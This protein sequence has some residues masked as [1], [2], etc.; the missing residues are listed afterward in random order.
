MASGQKDFL[1]S[2]IRD[3][4][5]M[6]FGQQLKLTMLLAVPAIL[7]QFSSVLMM[8]IDTAMVGHLGANPSASIGLV[9]TSTWI[10][11]GF[12]MA[13]AS[14]FSVQVAHMCGAKNF[15]GARRVL[16]QGLSSIF[17]FS[18]V[19]ALAGVAISPYLPAWLGGS[20]AI[21]ADASAYFRIYAAF[22]PIGA[23]GYGANAMLQGSGNMKVPSILYVSMCALD[24]V[25]NYLFIY[26]MEMG[27]AGAA[28][29]TGLA[30]AITT[31]V[32]LWFVLL[33]S[34]ELKI[35]GERGSFVPTKTV[36][37]NA[38][39]ITGPMWLQNLLM[40]GAHV[41][42]T[43]IVAPL[44]PIAIAANAFAIT[45]ESFCYMPGYGLEEAATT[46]VG[47]SLGASRKHIA[48]R[49]ARITIWMAAAIM[50]FLAV[51]MFF[52]ARDLM[53]LLSSDPDVIALGAKVLRIEAFAETFYAVSIVAY[54]ACVGAGDTLIPTALNFASMWVVR[55]GLAFYLTPR[56]GLVGYWIAMCIELNVRGLLFL[57]H[58]RGDRW[59][60]KRFTPV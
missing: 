49:F 47:Q 30:E 41:V 16:R 15:E 2:L 56:Y 23:V 43:V 57:F 60:R 54:G 19:F 51:L 5:E 59:M 31:A 12:T 37:G 25:L 52:F 35:V 53:T 8:Y 22:V 10:L 58:V 48:R 36:L 34:N 26:L 17:I 24:V 45:A 6:T 44:G 13:I 42:S 9:T 39:G 7:A 4:K 28:L 55:I 50:T 18:L 40:R 33:R 29:G 3:G 21:N 46:L 1:L 11:G 32:S 27:V 14:G 38:F 20:G